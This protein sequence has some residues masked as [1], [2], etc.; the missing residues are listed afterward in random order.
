MD[1]LAPLGVTKIG[2][3]LK[4]EKVWKAIKAGQNGG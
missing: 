1:A 3:P 4:P 2:M